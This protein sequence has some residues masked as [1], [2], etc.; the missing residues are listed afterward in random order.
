MRTTTL[1]AGLL[2]GSASPVQDGSVGGLRHGHTEHEYAFGRLPELVDPHWLDQQVRTVASTGRGGA[3]FPVA[4]KWAAAYRSAASLER[5]ARPSP[6]EASA[7]RSRAA[8]GIGGVRRGSTLR[9]PCRS[10]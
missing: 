9:C 7:N 2:G 6:R 10:S 5:I 8:C 3:H 4:A 1:S